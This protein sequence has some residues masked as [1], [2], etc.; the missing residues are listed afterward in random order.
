MIQHLSVKHVQGIQM[1]ATKSP[2]THKILLVLHFKPYQLRLSLIYIYS[3]KSLSYR[4]IMKF[5]SH[6]KAQFQIF[7]KLHTAHSVV[8]QRSSYTEVLFSFP[9]NKRG[10]FVAL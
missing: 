2:T 10:I 9:Q 4:K 3:S 8:S 1:I 6:T 5:I 7:I